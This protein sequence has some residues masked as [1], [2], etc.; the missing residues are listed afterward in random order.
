MGTSVYHSGSLICEESVKSQGNFEHSIEMQASESCYQLNPNNQ[1]IDVNFSLNEI[2]ERGVTQYG[3]QHYR[4]RCGFEP[5]AAM[6]YL[7]ADIV[8][9]RQ[10]IPLMLRAGIDMTFLG[11][12]CKRSYVHCVTLN[13]RSSK[14]ASI[15]VYAWGDTSVTHASSS[16][17]ILQRN[18]TTARAVESAGCCYSNILKKSHPCV[19][20][21]LHHDCPVCFEYLFESTND[22]SVL[23]CGHTIHVNCL[24]EMQQHLQYACPICCKSVCDMS[25][26]WEKLDIEIAATPMPESYH[27]LKVHILC[28]DCG[29]NSDVQFHIVAQKCLNCNS[30]NTRQIEKPASTPST[31]STA[32]VTTTR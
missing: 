5:L 29:V 27:N 17:T 22:V 16:M 12:K 7:I 15:V 1:G 26:V 20:G 28:N 21:A 32:S 25:K 24:K 13:N 14:C 30:Y 11:M 10:R 6:K 31:T 3:C 9:M 23:P 18:N 19:E 4:R 8:I 2:L